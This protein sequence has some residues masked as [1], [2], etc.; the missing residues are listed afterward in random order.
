MT[1]AAAARPTLATATNLFEYVHALYPPDDLYLPG[2]T[3]HQSARLL[4]L[5]LPRQERV[6]EYPLIYLADVRGR[7]PGPN[8]T[9]IFVN[10]FWALYAWCVP[11][12]TR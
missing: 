9:I 1:R 10:T 7:T 6:L 4:V 5:R 8:G 11:R 2:V 12:D 3:L